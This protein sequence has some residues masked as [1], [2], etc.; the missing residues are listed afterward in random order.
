VS[1]YVPISNTTTTGHCLGVLGVDVTIDDVNAAL[2]ETKR[3][4]I[5]VSIAAIAL[6][7]GV[8][9][10]L[11]H[12]LTRSVVALTAVVKRFA[13]KDYAARTG[14]LALRGDE[15]GELGRRFDA[16]AE[17][18]VAHDAMLEGLVEQRTAQ[19]A[20]AHAEVRD[21]RA[22]GQG[23][24]T[25]ATL[26]DFAIG[27]LIGR[28][29]M[30]EV[31]EA[32]APDGKPVAV[33][34]LGLHLL[35]DADSVRRF[36]REAQAIAAI[37][38]T[39][40]P[41]IVRLIATSPIDA[42]QP[43]L[44]MERLR[45][46]DL[47]TILKKTPVLAVAEIAGIVRAIA[48]GLDAAHA[49]GVVHRDLKPANVFAAEVDGEVREGARQ[50]IWKLL[51]FGVSKFRDG[52]ATLTADQVVGTPSYMAPEQACGEAV[53]ARTDVYAL[54]VMIYRLATGRPAVL[55]RDTPAML[56]DVVYRVP[57][58]PELDAR[59]EAVIAIAMAKRAAE[60][61]ASAGE[62]A[63]ALDQAVA[64]PADAVVARAKQLLDREPW[65]A[66]LANT[67][68]HDAGATQRGIA[69]EARTIRE[70]G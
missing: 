41:N 30:G 15:I 33:K 29:A 27:K 53:D 62:L 11:G 67:P 20:E 69:S 40:A 21:M 6:T 39:A 63:Q 18:V 60:R 5:A 54:G 50:V 26:G 23:R 56:L 58:K 52:G 7:L 9:L 13:G 44:V 2:A 36:Y 65:G 46:R 49:V 31:Y 51:D 55:P 4:E 35:G 24:F 59:I 47:N 25:G 19:L 32:S 3:L 37:D 70:R 8:A 61:F 45:G 48:A 1:A 10:V 12:L 14:A 57:A 16:M 64:D 34:V 22:P 68:G 66:W 38:A 17:I 28:G 42:P 43:Y